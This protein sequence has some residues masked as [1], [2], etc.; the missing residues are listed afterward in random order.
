MCA[1]TARRRP[2]RTANWCTLPSFLAVTGVFERWVSACP[3]SYSSGNA[4]T[5]RDVLG[6]LMLGLLAGQCH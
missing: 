1:G 5:K 2:R 6:T 4:P 3:L